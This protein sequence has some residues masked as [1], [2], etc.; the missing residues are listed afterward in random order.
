MD[1]NGKNLKQVTEEDL[2]SWAT[3]SADS[4]KIFFLGVDN[5]GQSDA[6]EA[7]SVNI[8]GADRKQLTDI[9]AYSMGDLSASVDGKELYFTEYHLKATFY[10]LS[11]DDTTQMK[12][13]HS[14][15]YTG[16]YCLSPDKKYVVFVEVSKES[17]SKSPFEYELFVMDMATGQVRQLT[18]L[19]GEAKNP[20]FF[21]N[22]DK[23][24]FFRALNWP[25]RN[26][27]YELMTVDLDGTHLQEIKLLFESAKS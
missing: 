26:P 19:H 17:R 2:V 21:H 5:Y 3:F 13:L 11:L 25:T 18:T 9:K 27:R 8:N 16:N 7:Y 14:G 1:I 12:P 23:L 15:E 22:Q 20:R 6:R 10:R 4:K 24:I